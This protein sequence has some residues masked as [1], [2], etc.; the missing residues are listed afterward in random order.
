MN[1]QKEGK[2]SK[3]CFLRS[4]F[5]HLEAV[6]NIMAAIQPSL[7][8]SHWQIYLLFFFQKTDKFSNYPVYHTVYETF[9]LVEKFYDPTFT[10]QLAIAKL[11]GKLVYELADSQVIPFDCRDYGE[12]LKGYSDR[13]YELAKKHEKQLETYGVSFGE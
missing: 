3:S 12:A 5:F 4:S 7:H 8:C 13:I 9:E 2:E 10:K 6:Q 11:R 1:T